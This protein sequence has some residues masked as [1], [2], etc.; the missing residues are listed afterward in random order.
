MSEKHLNPDWQRVEILRKP[1]KPAGF[2]IQM[3]VDNELLTYVQ[4]PDARAG[5]VNTRQLLVENTSG[6]QR[7]GRV[8]NVTSRFRDDY[9][10]IDTKLSDSID[11]KVIFAHMLLIEGLQQLPRR[12]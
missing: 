7:R 5:L 9:N 6:L 1:N 12:V 2:I 3:V 11:H 4:Q 10:R 8:Q